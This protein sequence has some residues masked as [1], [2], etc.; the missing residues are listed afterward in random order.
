VPPTGCYKFSRYKTGKLPDGK[1]GSSSNSNSN[2]DTSS[3]PKPLLLPPEGADTA[4]ATALAGAF[5]WAR[6]M[7]NTPAEDMGPQHLAAE[8]AAL[9][10]AHEGAPC[11]ACVNG[12][13]D[14]AHAA[15]HTSVLPAAADYAAR[16]VLL[17][18]R[19]RC[20]CCCCCRRQ[21]HCADWRGAAGSK[22]PSD[23]HCGARCCAA[24]LPDRAHVAAAQRQR[25]RQRGGHAAAAGGARRQR[26]DVFFLRVC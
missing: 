21:G 9:A 13:V 18:H 26:C 14:A 22:L 15:V 16:P 2:S 1:A 20:C 8:A 19:P 3:E 17:C 4:A 7:I 12:W 5:Y 23:T 11:G 6:D 24:P 25:Q 10:A